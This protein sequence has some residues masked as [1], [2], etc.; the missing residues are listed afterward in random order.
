MPQTIPLN[1]NTFKLAPEKQNEVINSAN[2]A[3][4]VSGLTHNYYKY[5]ARFSPEFVRS[6]INTFTKPGDTVFDPFM[7][8]GTTLVEAYAANRMSFGTDISSLAKFVSLAK[9]TLLS[10]YDIRKLETFFDF[11]NIELNIHL[12]VIRHK[13][14]EIKGYQK[15][16]GLKNIWRIRKLTEQALNKCGELK[17]PDQIR[18][19]R[20]TILRTAQW[21]IDG[22]KKIPTVA[23]FRDEM[24]FNFKNMIDSNIALAQKVQNKNHKPLCFNIPAQNIFNSKAS[25]KLK[26]P[27]LII[28]SPPYPGVH[29][30][31]HR[32]QVNGGKET[33]APFWIAN[34]LD[35]KGCAYYTMG[36]RK[37][38]KLKDYFQSTEQ[39]FRSLKDIS[40]QQ[41]IIVQMIGFGDTNWQLK[42]YLEVM[43]NSGY[44]EHFLEEVKSQ[45]HR[46]WRQVPNRKWYASQKGQTSSS[47]EVVLFHTLKR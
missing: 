43:D 30:L 32:W 35:G 14:W 45:D 46:L 19:A 37:Q 47:K 25:L 44:K 29:M 4:P 5:P 12:P 39:I 6:I 23:A 2:S 3:A 22:R 1:L 28:T 34:E 10:K 33:A 7:G 40:T 31:Y 41:T 11:I 26:K 42:K 9:T 18:F 16:L 13:E 8:G 38:N 24:K 15:H 20:C 36:D 21:A 17:N 27:K